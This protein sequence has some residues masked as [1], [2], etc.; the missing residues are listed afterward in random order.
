MHL[1][2]VLHLCTHLRC[3]WYSFAADTLLVILTEIF[4]AGN[5]LISP[6]GIQ[7][8]LAILNRRIL[9]SSVF[10]HIDSLPI[11]VFSFSVNNITVCICPGRCL[12]FNFY[13]IE[14]LALCRFQANRSFCHLTNQLVICFGIVLCLFCFRFCLFC[15]RFCLFCLWFCLFC[16]WF[17]FL[18]L[19][20]CLF[21]LRYLCGFRRLCADC[22]F[23]HLCADCRFF[24]RR[25]PRFCR[26]F[27]RRCICRCL[28]C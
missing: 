14:S 13:R 21:C 12:P 10:C 7:I 25:H 3:R 4:F 18:R 24:N 22:R 15:F 1:L 5:S 16:L 23:C 26:L 19:W 20:F 28:H 17:C 2:V 11:A 6:N 27:I 8:L 9:I